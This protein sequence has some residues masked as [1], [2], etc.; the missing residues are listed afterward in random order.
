MSHGQAA[1]E[2]GF[3]INK[4]ALKTNLSPEG[5]IAKRLVKDHLLAN[6]LKR[7]TIQITNPMVRAFKGARQSYV[8]YFDDENKKKIQTKDKEKTQHI[9]S[10]VENLKQKLKTNQKVVSMMENKYT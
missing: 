5:V 9:T 1:E 2:R 4:S 8:T 10:D 3:N 7:H 6:N